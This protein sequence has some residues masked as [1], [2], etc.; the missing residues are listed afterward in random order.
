MRHRH[1]VVG[2]TLGPD[3]TEAG[4]SSATADRQL[5]DVQRRFHRPPLQHAR[6]RSTPRTSRPE[7]RL[8][9]RVNPGPGAATTIKGTPLQVNGVLYFTIPDHVWALDART[10]REI[11]H[12]TWQSKG[13]IHIGNRGVAISGD[14]A[15]LRD[16]GLPS[17]VAQRR[18]TARSAGASR[19]AISTS[20]ITARSRRSSSRTTSSPASAAT[21]STCP[22]TSRRTIPN[23]RDAVA[24]VRRAA[25]EGRPG[26][27]DVA[28][29]RCDEAR[30]RHDVA[31]G[32][33]RSRAESDLRHDRQPAAGDRAQEPRGRQPLHRRRS[34]RSTPT[35]GKMAWYFQSS[36]HDTHDW[37]A[38]QTP[39]LFDGEVN[40]QP[41]KLLA[42]A[43]R[44]GY[45]FVLDRTNGKAL[46]STRVREDE[47][48]ERVRREGP[49]GSES[50]R[51]TRR[52][53]ARS[54]RR[55]RAAPRTGR[56]R[57]SARDRPLL[58]QRL[59]RVQR[60][61]HLRSGAR[62]RR[63]GAAPIAAA[64]ASR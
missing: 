61:L 16:A 35:R 46:I 33:L 37:D 41:R 45:F 44:N 24:L 27:G 11:W 36:P 3:R 29:R 38:T 18:R 26:I 50:R 59:A 43:A 12:Y 10:G 60:L 8:D 63:A 17:R 25:E 47:L 58:R 55:T 34:S 31:A 9:V 7:P 23:R 62:T 64:T 6:R 20:S 39:V 49:A 54:S 4:T 57:A 48:G 32:H 42:Q 2:W 56:R 52:S 21:T 13:G 15:V 22:A 51:R 1:V 14:Y 53:T 40:G 28:E 30:R 19:S 5:A